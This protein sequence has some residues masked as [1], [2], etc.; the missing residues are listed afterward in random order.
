MIKDNHIKAAGG[1]SN[2]F[3]LIRNN[4]PYT[5]SIEVETSNLEEIKEA[6]ANK[7]DIIMLDNMS[8]NMMSQGCRN[9]SSTR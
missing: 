5:L 6:L 2:A 1:I 4:I 7:A 8:L 3:A 9:N